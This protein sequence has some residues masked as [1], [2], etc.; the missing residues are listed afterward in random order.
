M[1]CDKGLF[2]APGPPAGIKASPLSASSVLVSWLPPARPNGRIKH[3][4]LYVREASHAGAHQAYTL[5]AN[6]SSDQELRHAVSGLREG[7][8]Y[9]FW[10]SATT[11]FGEG[12]ATDVLTQEP[13]SKSG[14][15]LTIILFQNTK[16]PKHRYYNFS[17]IVRPDCPQYGH[18][19]FPTSK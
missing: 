19:P 12:K 8:P 16:Y 3:Y 5:A 4:T 2:A 6:E 1:M 7:L 15:F 9:E 17:S 13:S 10:L 18:K 11:A 14:F